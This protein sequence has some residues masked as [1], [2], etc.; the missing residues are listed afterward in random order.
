[1]NTLTKIFYAVKPLIPRRLQIYIRRK[2]AARLLS[3]NAD[4][5][6]INEEASKLPDCWEQW[7]DKKQFALVITHDVE[8]EEGCRNSLRLAE[9]EK[10]IGF[11]SSFSFVPERYKIPEKLL[12]QIRKLG[13]EIAVHGLKHDGKLFH[14]QKIFLKRADRINYYLRCWNAKGFYSPSMHRN[15]EFMH[16]LDIAYD[17]STFDT[18]PF[19]PQPIGVCSIFPFTIESETKHSRY[20]ELPYTLAQDH[21]LFIVLKMT[22]IRCWKSKLD[23]IATKG[24]MALIKT[25]PDYMSFDGSVKRGKYPVEYYIEFLKYIKSKYDGRYWHVLPI[26]MAEFWKKY[27]GK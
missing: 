18:D 1:M 13:F 15:L 20:I 12:A 9:L 6:P 11:R 23:W 26:Q 7:P 25:H 17:Q 2:K 3:E 22:N 10:A 24:G 27:C 19:E 14:S 16:K 21:T 4:I 8:L 5:W